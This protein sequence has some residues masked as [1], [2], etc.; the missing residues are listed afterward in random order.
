MQVNRSRVVCKWQFPTRAAGLAA[1]MNVPENSATAMCGVI[2]SFGD[3]APREARQ[4]QRRH[5]H[6]CNGDDVLGAGRSPA[7][8]TRKQSYWHHT[9]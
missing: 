8:E 4:A 3:L 7:G 2:A 9:A 6:P 5:S 1:C